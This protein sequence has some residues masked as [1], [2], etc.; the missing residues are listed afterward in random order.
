MRLDI[1]S[2]DRI[3]I[4]NDILN[5]F[6]DKGWDLGAMEMH[7]HHTYVFI[8]ENVSNQNEASDTQ[9][10]INMIDVERALLRIS[11][12]EKI[13]PI[14][15]LPSEQK[16]RHLNALLE[17]LPDPILDVNNKGEVL[18]ANHAA[19]VAFSANPGELEGQNIATLT[20]TALSDILN[21]DPLSVD[22]A[23]NNQSFL[24]DITPIQMEKQTS[25]AVIMLRSPQRLGQEIS[26]IQ[27]QTG[28]SIE[29]II[30]NSV[31][32]KAI[33]QQTKRFSTLDMPVLIQGETGTGKELFAR[34]LHESGPRANAPFLAINCATLAENLLE[35]ELFGYASGAFPG[36]SRGG[37]PGLFELAENGTVFLDEIGEMSIYLQA[38]LLRFLQEFTFRRIGGTREIK[39]NVRIVCATHQSLD[40]LVQA[41]QFREDLYYRLNVLNLN[42]PPLRERQE[43][44]PELVNAFAINAAEQIN[45]PCPN[46]ATRSLQ[47]LIQYQWPGNVRQLQNVI[48]RTL[49]LSDKALIEVDDLHIN[50]DISGSMVNHAPSNQPYEPQIN[51]QVTNLASA[52]AE[53]EKKLLSELY[54]EFPSS[55]K[56]AKR[57]DVSHANIHRKLKKYQLV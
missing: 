25:G 3:G 54:N 28:N 34:A 16:R 52:I 18:V 20:K 50:N 40:E 7:L 21:D 53:F 31:T 44:I 45:Q 51:E 19:E 22:I 43:D 23:I 29:S 48:F 2:E 26:A 38:K 56:L 41:K 1:Q 24:M 37:K 57:L 6:A 4:T 8:N 49:A 47:T 32:M 42:L 15:Y 12:V 9:N 13:I 46:F 10:A 27:P 33:K 35:S 14:K 17:K 36:A 39:V 30:G 55:R 11:G 5:T